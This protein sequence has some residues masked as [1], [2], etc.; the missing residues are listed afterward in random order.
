MKIV[1]LDGHTTNPGDLSYDVF[2]TFGDFTWYDRTE[3]TKAGVLQRARDAEIIIT[4]KTPITAEIIDEL[5]NCRY[6]GLMST[7]FDAV[8][9]K[10]AISKGITVC[11]VPSY[12]SDAV[13]QMTF[14]LILANYNRA[15][16][17]SNMVHD[18]AWTRCADFCFWDSPLAELRG[19]TI[20]LFGFGNI[21][22]AVADVALAFKM[23]VIAHSRSPFEYKGVESVD[24]DTLLAQSDILSL[25]APFNEQTNNIIN[26][27]TIAK[28]KDGALLINTARGKLVDDNA[29]AEALRSGK[30]RGAG[31]D[32]LTVEPP[33]DG[34][35]L[36][37]IKN[38]I[39]TPHIS[40]AAV[41]TRER[42]VGIVADNLRAFLNGTP[43]NEVF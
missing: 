9:V 17:H 25:H 42:L 1:M 41:E 3:K 24:L 27:S 11:N 32:V 7:G 30:L 2:S 4:N 5:T 37:G 31:L 39:I 10:H 43:Q 20:G 26:A 14:A 8:D 40:W 6:I 21:A 23:R 19:K 13:A 35:P 36:F 28:M 38:C 33:K 18:G 22:K 34:N 29:L 15:E 16:H 12:T